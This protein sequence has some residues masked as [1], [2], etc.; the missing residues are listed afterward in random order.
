MEKLRQNLI[1]IS[2]D[3]SQKEK[4]LLREYKQKDLYKIW[5]EVISR[6]PKKLSK[7]WNNLMISLQNVLKLEYTNTSTFN[8]MISK[9]RKPIRENKDFSP[10]IYK[11]SLIVL[12]RSREE[13][14][15]QKD[16]YSAKVAARNAGRVSYPVLYVEDLY[17]TM[18]KLIRSN[19]PYELTLAVQ[20]STSSRSIEVFKVSKYFSVLDQPNQI[21]IVGL[22]KDKMG[23]N[24]LKDIV[25]IRN[26]VY[27]TSDQILEA[28]EKIRNSFN[29][30][31]KSNEEISNSTNA[32]LNKAFKKNIAPLF[33]PQD[34][35]Y[36]K[37]LSSHKT[38]YISGYVSYLIYGK[39]NKIPEESYIGSQLGHLNAESTRSYLGINI[40]MKEKIIQNSPDD[41]KNLFQHEI[42]E[43]KKQ[44]SNL[45]PSE[46]NKVDVDL[47]ELKNSNHRSMSESD[48]IDAV[49]TAL[50]LF[51][52]KKIKISQRELRS[53][54][55]YA[56]NI[57]TAAY[58]KARASGVI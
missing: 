10:E 29:F 13:A 23:K 5:N 7:S 2:E 14:A 19:D 27:L 45:F 25:S 17:K 49:I 21:E 43:I 56:S 51:R 12:G 38:R 18:Y 41:I 24:N 30:E 15:Q 36:L 50:K 3:I 54:L 37:T 8:R 48:K 57:M 52:E 46:S 16:A 33:H 47:A 42:K 35:D 26:L 44:V 4:I 55:N 11:H 22:A 53:R 31:N 6:A 58:K 34:E 39:P 20:L 9:F 32:F 1:K 40:Q 28:V